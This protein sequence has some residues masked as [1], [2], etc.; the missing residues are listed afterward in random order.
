M[1][2]VRWTCVQK[3]N[4]NDSCPCGSGKKYKVCCGAAH[5]GIEYPKD[6]ER[7]IRSRYTAYVIGDVDYL[8]KTTHPSNE[9]V[10][11]KTEE[12]Y[13]NETLGYCQKVDFTGLTVHET[14]PEDDQGISRGML[15]ARFQVGNQPEDSFT[16]RSEFIP[17][18][19]RLLYLRGT[20]VEPPQ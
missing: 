2:I 15:T 13:K 6:P 18:D 5:T 9:A 11:G 19:G 16:E 7:M 8:Y 14:S 10:A 12:A 17:V 4:R 3:V 20:E 1:R